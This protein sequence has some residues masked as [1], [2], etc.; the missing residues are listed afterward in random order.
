M[1]T[2][3]RQRVTLSQRL[4]TV[5]TT[6]PGQSPAWRAP[7]GVERIDSVVATAPAAMM[8]KRRRRKWMEFR[9]TE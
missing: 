7:G 3:G 5:M 2:V 8:A 6:D 9:G 4:V 1:N